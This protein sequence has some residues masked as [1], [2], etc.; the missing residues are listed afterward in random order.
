MSVH[1]S[2]PLIILG[3]HRSG[4]SCLAGTLEQAGVYLGNVSHYNEYN[5]KGNRENARTMKL[6]ELILEHC[7]GS[8][9]NPPDKLEWTIEHEIEGENIIQDY[10]NNCHSN[11]WGFK[12]PRV[13]LTLPFWKKL[14]PKALYIGTFRAPLRVAQSL[15]NRGN[16]SIDLNK[17]L[18]LWS[19]YNKRLINFHK[20]APFPLISFDLAADLYQKELEKMCLAL[21]LQQPEKEVFFD[22]KLRSKTKLSEQ[23]LNNQEIEAIYKTL[24]SL[25]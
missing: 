23:I 13:L 10:K 14:L 6:N 2:T 18:S 7:G 12:D 19:A 11:Y 3:M 24:K 25:S 9:D 1:K 20:E 17:G 8:W 16:S 15:L 5:K 22:N 4:T 21:Q